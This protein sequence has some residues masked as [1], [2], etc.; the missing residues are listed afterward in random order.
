MTDI[1]IEDF[2]AK[3]REYIG[4]PFRH[5]GRVV[6]KNGGLDCG[7]MIILAMTDVGLP[8]IDGKT[9]TKSDGISIIRQ[10]LNDNCIQLDNNCDIS[11]GNL[12]LLRGRNMY[13][14]LVYW[15]IAGT[16]IHAWQTT[17]VNKVVESQMLP[18]W[19]NMIDSVWQ[20]KGLETW[21]Q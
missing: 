16:I 15:T 20:I 9:Y 3:L 13:H 5:H 6:G 21:E 12:I 17:G 8:A 11:P 7:G 1:K 2:D 4:T 19:W 10:S 18:E 14:H